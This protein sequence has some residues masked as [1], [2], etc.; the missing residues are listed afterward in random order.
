MF[1][2]KEEKKVSTYDPKTVEKL[3]PFIVLPDSWISAEKR[4]QIIEVIDQGLGTCSTD[5]ELDYHKFL[6]EILQDFQAGRITDVE[7][8]FINFVISAY[9]FHVQT[10]GIPLDLK[11]LV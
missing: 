4:K 2:K 6:S 11:T 7:F 8:M 9:A 1:G 3:K 10:T 5:G